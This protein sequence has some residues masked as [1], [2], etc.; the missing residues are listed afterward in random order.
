MKT[1]HDDE[2]TKSLLQLN[3]QP[4]PGSTNRPTPKSGGLSTLLEYGSVTGSNG[5]IIQMHQADIPPGTSTPPYGDDAVEEL[6]HQDR[7]RRHATKWVLVG[8]AL[9]VVVA[10]LW[11]STT[12][13]GRSHTTYAHNEA[14]N[15]VHEQHG[16]IS[17]AAAVLS[18]KHPVKDLHIPLVERPDSSAPHRGLFQEST[19]QAAL[20]T[21]AWYQNL[22]LREEPTEEQRVYPVPYVV[23]VVGPISGLRLHHPTVTAGDTVV[24]L[25]QVLAHG[26]TLGAATFA[27][28]MGQTSS[29]SSS[30]NKDDQE[31]SQSRKYTIS[32]MTSLGITLEWVRY[33]LF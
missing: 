29:S 14:T 12:S 2:E 4:S 31:A 11:H 24:Q 28:L 30:S 16:F 22:L 10:G 5:S 21:N 26:L 15:S 1:T 32:K 3:A 6:S 27:T 8:A 17:R 33:C 19:L 9:L 13:S 18:E 7:K 23:D 20:P 25:T